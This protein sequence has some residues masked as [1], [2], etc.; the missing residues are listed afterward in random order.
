MSFF[1][2]L[3]LAAIAAGRMSKRTIKATVDAVQEGLDEEEAEAGKRKIESKIIE[4]KDKPSD[5]ADQEDQ[6]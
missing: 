4:D 2:K 3:K 6:K 5:T 1:D